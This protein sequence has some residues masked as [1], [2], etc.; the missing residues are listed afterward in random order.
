MSYQLDLFASTD[1]APKLAG[2][3]PSNPNAY[4]TADCLREE[5]EGM[6]GY[7]FEILYVQAADG[8]H[9]SAGYMFPTQGSCGPVFI[10]TNA[11]P[12]QERARSVALERL[13]LMVNGRQLAGD[14]S[15]AVA[16]RLRAALSNWTAIDKAASHLEAA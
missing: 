7:W 2:I 10:R 1:P 8:W 6:P 14:I 15:G 13:R 12:T 16:I 3:H 9:F 5:V 4:A 11:Y